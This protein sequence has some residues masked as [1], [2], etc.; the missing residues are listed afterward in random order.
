MA[1]GV[2][3]ESWLGRSAGGHAPHYCPPTRPESANVSDAF[4]KHILL[5]RCESRIETERSCLDFST[6]CRISLTLIG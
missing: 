1:S 3:T 4:D 5:T 2:N 6:V